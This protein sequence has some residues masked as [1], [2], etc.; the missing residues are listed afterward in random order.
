MYTDIKKVN[1]NFIVEYL[2]LQGGQWWY[3]GNE[4]RVYLTE[5]QAYDIAGIVATDE[6]KEVYYSSKTEEIEVYA[7]SS[8]IEKWLKDNIEDN[9]LEEAIYRELEEDIGY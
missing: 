6:I 9:L 2:T 3:N 4:E 5:N 8:R 7:A 1:S